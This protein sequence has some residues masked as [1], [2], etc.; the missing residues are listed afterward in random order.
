MDIPQRVHRLD[1]ITAAQFN[2]GRD[3]RFGTA[4]PEKL[5]IPFQNAMI[6]GNHN[7]WSAR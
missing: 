4:N 5:D 1:D 3:R 6:K 2:E 7:A